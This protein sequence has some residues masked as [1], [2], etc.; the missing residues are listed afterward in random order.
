MHLRRHRKLPRKLRRREYTSPGPNFA[1]HVDG[2]DKLEDYGFLIHGAVDGFSQKILRLH[3]TKT[4]N[5][6]A[7]TAS[8]YLNCVREQAGCPV[9][10]VTDP[11][12]KNPVIASM[13]CI[14]RS[15]RN[16]KYGGVI[17]KTWSRAMT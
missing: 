7:V 10:L 3:E 2:Y 12:S 17:P 13:Q 1:W 8:F 5:D 14:L 11:G 4:S 9:L 16:D 15:D 6:P